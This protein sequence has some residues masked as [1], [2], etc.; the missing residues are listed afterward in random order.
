M[1]TVKTIINKTKIDIINI[2]TLKKAKRT[3]SPITAVT[4]KH[5]NNAIELIQ[6]W[7]KKFMKLIYEL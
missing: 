3:I 5:N 1:I 2:I 4:R 7:N 6:Q